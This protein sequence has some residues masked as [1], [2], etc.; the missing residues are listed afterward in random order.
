MR[1]EIMSLKPVDPNAR[2]E[3]VATCSVQ[4]EINDI[5]SNFIRKLNDVLGSAEERTKVKKFLEIYI[6]QVTTICE[7][8]VERF[9]ETQ[10]ELLECSRHIVDAGHVIPMYNHL[11]TKKLSEIRETGDET[12]GCANL[13]RHV[14]DLQGKL[15]NCENGTELAAFVI[16]ANSLRD[17]NPCMNETDTNESD[18]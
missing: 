12:T 5:I 7:N 6:T 17:D 18:E 11:E 3:I 8:H 1:V 9:P 15:E 10:A 14:K 13:R 16:L 4:T 2:N